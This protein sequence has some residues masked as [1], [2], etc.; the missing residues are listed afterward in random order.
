MNA[1]QCTFVY[2]PQYYCDIGPH[3]FPMAKFERVYRKLREE[4]DIPDERFLTAEPATVEEVR[5]VHT[6]EY[7]DDMLALRRTPRT[8]P[9]ELPLTEEIIRAYFLAAGGTLLAARAAL[10][11]GL[12]MNL[13]GGFHHAFPDH[14]E[15]FCYVNDVAVALRGL[16]AEGLV[17]RA[18]VVDCDVHQ[19]NGTAVIFQADPTVFTFSMHQEN[20]YPIKQRSD[21]DIG[22]RDGATDEEYLLALDEKLPRILDSCRPELVLYVAGADSFQEDLLGGLALTFEGL[23]RRDECVIGHCRQRKIPLAAVLAGGYAAN[24]EDTVRIHHATAR[25]MW[26]AGGGCLAARQADCQP[27]S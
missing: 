3:V 8:L 1:S 19:G 6:E 22:L 27:D 23:R 9:S 17:R 11:N 2:S 18:A 25:L 4:G 5:R 7:V 10:E 24:L 15:G 21:L 20:N 12:A 26:E 13:T 16:K 14:G